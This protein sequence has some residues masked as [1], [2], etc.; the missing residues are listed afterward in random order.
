M[1][2]L[3]TEMLVDGVNNDSFQKRELIKHLALKII[4]K[5][6]ISNGLLLSYRLL[7]AVA[8]FV[9]GM[10]FCDVVF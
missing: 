6:K 1:K 10:A 3:P 9:S 2:E 5:K 7:G 8:I 4:K